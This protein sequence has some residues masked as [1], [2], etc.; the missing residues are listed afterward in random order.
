M[1]T[2]RR[3]VEEFCLLC[4]QEHHDASCQWRTGLAC[5]PQA[6]LHGQQEV[7]Y[8]QWQRIRYW[9]MD[10]GSTTGPDGS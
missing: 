1:A 6:L 7:H 5:G 10:Q 9:H 8:S 4:G 2:Y 3:Q